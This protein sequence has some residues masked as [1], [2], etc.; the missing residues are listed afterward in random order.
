[1]RVLGVL[2]AFLRRDLAVDVSYRATFALQ[3]VSSLFLL[4]LFFYLSRVIDQAEFSAS[5]HLSSGYFGY[6]AV[7]LGL[8]QIVQVSLGSFSRKLRDE[9]T[10][11]TFEA[12]MSTPASPSLII[13]SSAAY[14]LLRATFDGL[15]LI[16]AAIVIFGLDID[17]GVG[18]L[19]V[20]VVA[21]LGCIGLFASIGV[22][23][24]AF[25]VIFKR[26]TAFLGVVVT[27]L[28]LLGGVYFPIEVMPEPLETVAR[29]IPF[30]WGLDVVRA[31]LLGGEVDPAKLGGLFASVA[32]LMPLALLGFRASLWRARRTGTLA[33]Y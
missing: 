33:Q 32:V 13:L 17:A 26:G 25:T 21:M 19:T 30:T 4:A 16:A 6:A 3:L 10:T 15:L 22:V 23:V 11:G 12:L 29:A 14:D 18:G 2:A 31:A 24:A 28:A 20:A 9:Q 27:A 8:L 7:G 1:M 5:Q